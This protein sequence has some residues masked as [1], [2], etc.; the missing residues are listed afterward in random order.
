MAA[1]TS[2]HPPANSLTDPDFK[3]QL[4][5]LRQTDN[6]RNWFYLLRTYALPWRCYWRL[7]LVLSPNP[8]RRPLHLLE[9]AGVLPAIVIVGA[10]QHHLANLAHEAVHHTLFKNRFLN[11]MVSEWCCS[12]PM[13]S[14][15]FHYGLHHLAHHQFVN[16][17]IRDPDISQLQQS[18]HRLTFPIVR[19]EFLDVL[20]RQM[21]VP[22]LVRV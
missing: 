22:N 20:F 12:F 16:D 8:L 9:L 13:L 7:D 2:D 6:V 17:P 10:L 11:D 5:R 19:D 21:W 4:Q 1:A 3:K 15:T 18:G 14:S